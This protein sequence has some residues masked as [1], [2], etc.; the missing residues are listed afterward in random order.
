MVM[1]MR[2]REMRGER[3]GCEKGGCSALFEKDDGG[4][5]STARLE[6]RRKQPISNKTKDGMNEVQNPHNSYGERDEERKENQRQNEREKSR[7]DGRQAELGCGM[8][9][10]AYASVYRATSSRHCQSLC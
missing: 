8:R 3:L 4:E 5:E 6:K 9:C 2:M 7:L 10:E 1:R